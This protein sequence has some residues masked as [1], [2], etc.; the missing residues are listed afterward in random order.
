MEFAIRNWNDKVQRA[1]RST[2]RLPPP[3]VTTLHLTQKSAHNHSFSLFSLKAS[4]WNLRETNLSSRRWPISKSEGLLVCCQSPFSCH[5]QLTLTLWQSSCWEIQQESQR[6]QYWHMLVYPLW[7]LLT[8]STAPK[9]GSRD[10]LRALLSS[11]P[12]LSHLS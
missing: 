8:Y 6:G 11:C 7:T 2:N 3:G 9:G 12:D 5:M 1:T 10:S 4:H